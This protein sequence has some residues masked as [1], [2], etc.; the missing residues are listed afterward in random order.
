MEERS[1]DPAIR[2][3]YEQHEKA[4]RDWINWMNGARQ[5][6]RQEGKIEGAQKV[7]DLIKSGKTPEE[8]LKIIGMDTK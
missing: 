3:E 6:G 7:F 4:R 2:A 5:E 8:A 1:A